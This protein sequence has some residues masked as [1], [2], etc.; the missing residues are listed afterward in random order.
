MSSSFKLKYKQNNKKNNYNS[1]TFEKEAKKKLL[2]KYGSR[3][4]SS[5]KNQYLDLVMENL[6][7]NKNSHLVTVFKDYMIWDYCDE[8]FKRFY[9]KRESFLRVPKFSVFYKNYLK[10]FCI[11]TL[12]DETPNEMIHTCSEKKA[13]LFYKENYQRKKKDNSELKDCGIYQDSASDEGESKINYH[14]ISKMIFFNESA[15]KKIE[16][17]SP[18]NT[19]IVLNESETKLKEDESGLLVTVSEIDSFNENSLRDI[20]VQLKK[21]VKKI[22]NNQKLILYANDYISSETLNKNRDKNVRNKSLDILSN[23]G[24]KN[25]QL[26]GYNLTKNKENKDPLYNIVKKD[27]KKKYDKYLVNINNNSNEINK[28]KN[29]SKLVTSFNNKYNSSRNQPKNP[30]IIINSNIYLRNKGLDKI[31]NI[32]KTINLNLLKTKN[33]QNTLG[34]N[35]PSIYINSNNFKNSKIFNRNTHNRDNITNSAKSIFLKNENNLRMTNYKYFFKNSS[36][37]QSKLIKTNNTKPNRKTER[38]LSYKNYQKSENENVKKN[39]NNLINS[40]LSFDGIIHNNSN[41]KYNIIN[42]NE[43]KHIHNINININNHYNIGSKQFQEIFTFSDLLKQQNKN[44]ATKNANLQAFL[45]KNNKNVNIISRNKNQNYGLNSIINNTKNNKMNSANNIHNSLYKN[46]IY[47][48]QYAINKGKSETIYNPKQK[49][50]NKIKL[51][52]D[53]IFS[54]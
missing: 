6:I 42:Y 41:K 39:N 17:I 22:P 50:T 40:K 33:F 35:N 25:T 16:R 31:N 53:H 51:N 21:K 48:S 27:E 34:K 9:F 47:R 13:E 12:K 3:N 45:K 54:Y 24:N 4:K 2:M 20:M 15:R 11:P 38:I 23:N 19:S 36:Y 52:S 30:Q 28:K 26:T 43:D 10:F 5:L 32:K 14:N 49:R 46:N 18:I 1:I 44:N 8:F 37:S 29:N 7:F